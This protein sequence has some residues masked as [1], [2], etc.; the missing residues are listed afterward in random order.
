MPAYFPIIYVRGF[1]FTDREIE[2]TTDDP[3]NGFN[4][5]TTHARQRSLGK[6]L[7][8]RFPGPFVRLITDH[9]YEDAIHGYED[10]VEG[11]AIPRKTLWI[12]R[13]YEPYSDTFAEPGKGGRPSIVEAAQGLLNLVNH[14]TEVCFGKEE[15]DKRVILIAHSMG[16]L[17]C[18]SLIQ[19]LLGSEAESLIE[20]VVTYGTPH[21][22]IP[23]SVPL[24]SYHG[25]SNFSREELFQALAPPGTDEKKFDPQKLRSFDPKRFLCV[26]GTN[27][28]DYA[29]GRGVVRSLVGPAS[30]GLVQI[31]HA[32]VSQA[33]RVYVYR[34]HSGRYGLVSSA[35]AWA[36]VEVSFWRL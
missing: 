27:H 17:V 1:A 28:L 20:K 21:G 8:Y 11:V 15:E 13:F 6:P 7:K 22:G 2:E 36:A 33:P 34:S 16:G 25:L 12:H 32:W 35:E 18:R 14:V 29:V 4:I 23:F 30:D 9:G 3:T 31:R 24:A 26:V 5:G 19:R 10:S